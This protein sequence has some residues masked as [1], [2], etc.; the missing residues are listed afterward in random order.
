MSQI[1]LRSTKKQRFKA[2]VLRTNY[3]PSH[4]HDGPHAIEL[5]ARKDEANMEA[6]A[7]PPSE[8]TQRASMPP[9]YLER[10]GRERPAFFANWL[11]E[12]L[13]VASVVMSIVMSEYFI[14]GFNI[15]LPVVSDAL[16]IPTRARTW[17]AGVMNLTT[18]ALLLPS[19]RLCDLYGSRRVFF[20]GHAWLIIWSL[21]GGFSGSTTM[22]IFCRA[23]QGIGAAAFL[24]SSL[25]LL[26]RIYRPGPRKN[27]IFSIYGAFSCIGFIIGI[28][29]GGL[30]SEFLRWPW[31]FWIGAIIGAFTALCGALSIPALD[32]TTPGARMDWLGVVTIVPGLVLVIFALTDGGHAPDGWRTPYIY[33]TLCLGIVF[34]AAAVYSQGWAASKPLLPG[35]IFKH[36]Y[37]KRL[38][39]VL[40]LSYGICGLCLFYAS[41]YI[42]TVMQA[43]PLLTAAYFLPMAIG[44]I[45]LAVGG[46][47]ILHIIPNRFMMLV[48]SLGFMLQTL[49]WALI[50]VDPS[51]STTF[52]YWA[53]V[54][55]AMLAGTIG[56]DIA[57][58]V[59]NIYITTA[60]PKR[61]QAA[62]S[63]LSNSL[64]YLGI[65]F[66]LGVTELAVSTAVRHR[67]DGKVGLGEQYKI[68]FYVGVG[69]SALSLALTLTIKIGQAES[70][71]TAD[72]KAERELEMTE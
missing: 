50:P 58:N 10:L 9:E 67:G 40:F 59:G 8:A 54:M 39:A 41:F 1:K 51:K 64:V 13:F 53:Y 36:R 47:F 62:A 29:V 24:P 32:D 37:I 17:P 72:E 14:A 6:T 52:L 28:V 26:A 16:T 60:V 25:A 63:G 69:L 61:H 45:V 66:W 2:C 34:L 48:S 22:L 30:V 71:L 65:A 31:Y 46:G 70:A 44:G 23:M 18:A 3:K 35:D 57:F 21:A 4:G 15:I 68:A 12:V 38:V 27:I 43:S 20:C 49:L 7:S 33:T 56:V 11:T 42:E 19:S 55:P 5:P